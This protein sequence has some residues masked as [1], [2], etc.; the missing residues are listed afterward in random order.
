MLK[1]LIDATALRDKPSGIGLYIYHLIEELSKIQ[2]QNNFELQ[3]VYQPSIKNWLKVNL[4]P[5]QPLQK[6]SNLYCLPIPVSLSHLIAN[7]SSFICSYFDQYL[8]SPNLIHGTD[9]VVYPCRHALKVMTIHDLTFI[10]YPNFVNSRVK[11]YTQ[12]VK[13]C[14]KWTDLVLTVS[15]STKLDIIQYLGVKEEKIYVTPLASRYTKVPQI[16]RS[17][18]HLKPYILFVSTIEPRKNVTNLIVAFNYLKQTHKIE[19]KLVL[20]GQKGWEYTSIF[21]AIENSFYQKDIHHL[22]YLSDDEVAYFYSQADVFV[23][24]SIYE[25]F[26]LPVL[27]AMTLG[28]P[29]ITSNTSSLPEIAGDAAIKIDPENLIQIAEAI[30]E[31][32]S[33][34]QLR[35][36]L[37]TKGKER[38]KL[39][40]WEKTAKQTLN[41]YKSIL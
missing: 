12:R 28:T 33:S 41:A 3:I 9:H 34:S 39:F 27:E 1:I 18:E 10:K 19:H 13:Q 36:S 4:Y 26:G 14:L 29:V 15:Q 17:I 24:P 38:V 40:S 31:V 6:Y 25:G 5:F 37:I 21:A 11:T 23:Y 2:T 16:S 30:L 35:Q 8:D 7:H 32:I 20:I 22:D